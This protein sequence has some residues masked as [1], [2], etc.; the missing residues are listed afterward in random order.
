MTKLIVEE[1]LRKKL[2]N[3]EDKVELCDESGQTFGFFL[4][5]APQEMKLPAGV[6]S[7]FSE[8]ELKR[9]MREPGGRTLAEIWAELEKS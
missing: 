1:S 3:L 5:W 7:P 2:I 4:P 8:E 6:E 9:R